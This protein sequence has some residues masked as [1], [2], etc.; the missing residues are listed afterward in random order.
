MA[1]ITFTRIE[2]SGNIND[3]DIIDGQIIMCGDGKLFVD[4]DTTRVNAGGL[5]GQDI[6]NII[7]DKEKLE[8]EDKN[9]IVNSI[10]E[11]FDSVFY[12]DGDTFEITFHEVSLP[13][14]VTTGSKDFFIDIPTPKSMKNI[15]KIEISSIN[16]YFRHPEGGYIASPASDNEWSNDSIGLTWTATKVTD[17][18]ITIRIQTST[19]VN[20]TN[21]IPFI[22]SVNEFKVIFKK[23]EA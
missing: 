17:N 16:L 10:N 14:H 8:T 11:I 15:N 2:N 3:I 19:A 23:N 20:I 21:N 9:T 12:K 13:G 7:G 1:K 4:Y 18:L 5:N 22:A 6:I